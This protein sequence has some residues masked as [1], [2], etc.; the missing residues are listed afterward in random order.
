MAQILVGA[1]IVGSIGRSGRAPLRR[2]AKVSSSA[3]PACRGKR[4]FCGTAERPGNGSLKLGSTVINLF[5]P[6]KVNL[7]EHWKACL[8]RKLAS[9]WQYLPKSCYARR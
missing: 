4:R 5:A 7:V 3:G 2:R 1:T 9:R 6:G 8:L